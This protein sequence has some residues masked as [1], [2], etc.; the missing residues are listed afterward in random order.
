MLVQRIV[1][2]VVK[3]LRFFAKKHSQ[4]YYDLGCVLNNMDIERRIMEI[5]ES[6]H[7]DS[8]GNQNEYL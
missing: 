3:L 6:Y 4:I 5:K 1:K 8:L 7:S 2:I